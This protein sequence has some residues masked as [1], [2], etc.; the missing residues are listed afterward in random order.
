MSCIIITSVRVLSPKN[1]G[2]TAHKA[3]KRVLPSVVQ[4]MLRSPSAR[5]VPLGK[6]LP[7]R[8]PHLLR[9]LESAEL[10]APPSP[11]PGAAHESLG[12]TRSVCLWSPDRIGVATAGTSQPQRANSTGQPASRARFSGAAISRCGCR[13]GP[14]RTSVPAPSCADDRPLRPGPQAPGDLCLCGLKSPPLL[15][16]LPTPPRGRR[17]SGSALTPARCCPRGTRPRSPN[18]SR[19]SDFL[20]S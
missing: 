12:P 2:S 8:P 20:R 14:Q 1:K 19:S 7:R 9:C 6:G 17:A 13:S 5:L 4:W 3:F 18:P 16:P 15:R 11:Q 10:R